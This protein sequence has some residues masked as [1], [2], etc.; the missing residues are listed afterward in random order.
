MVARME[1]TLRAQGARLDKLRVAVFGA[2]G[3]VGFAAGV[4]AALQGAEVTLAGYDGAA[5]VQR[6]AEDIARRFGAT[7]H[8]A[9]ASSEERKAAILAAA[10]AVF[11][12]GP[13]GRRLLS[14]EQL[15]AAPDLLVVADVNAV[16]PLG[17]EGVDLHDDGTPIGGG[18]TLG[19]GALAIGGTK[20][21][22]EFGLFRKMIESEQP[23]AYDFRDAFVLARELAGVSG[24]YA[25]IA[26]LSARA[27]AGSARR[28]GYLPLVA[29]LFGDLDTRAAAHSYARAGSLAHGFRRK[30]LLDALDALAAGRAPIGL[31]Y[32]SGFEDRPALLDAIGERHTA[33]GQRRGHRGA[34]QGSAGLCRAVPRRMTCRIPK[35]QRVSRLE[36]WGREAWLVKRIGGAGGT[37][38]THARAGRTPRRGRYAQRWVAGRP[39][40]ALF[41]GDG[42]AGVVL[43]FSAQWC[44]PLP[45][46][47]YRYGGA[48]RPAAVSRARA[49]AMTEAIARMIPALG[50]RGLNSADFLLRDDGFDLIEIN[51]RPGATLD[52]HPDA[53]GELFSQHVRACRG[54]LP[55]SAPPAEGAS[56]AAIVYAPRPLSVREG[57]AW[58][59]WT[60]DRQ[61][62]GPVA[63]HAP[64][65]TVR[66][67]APDA[68]GARV[69]AVERARSILALVS[70]P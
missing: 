69:V 64:L 16:P 54:K 67:E 70:G 50:L 32:G 25:L 46:R 21:R 19:I 10:Q 49:E 30:R 8:P 48:V 28:A 5:R 31:V 56:A 44:D 11:C 55:A 33:A 59:D 35:P 1:R 24:D 13:A 63:H 37:H 42:S 22:T 17:V 45:R 41:L 14:A 23:V 15:R 61:P 66:A 20:Y 18:K 43:G 47:P 53:G 2:T 34:H 68:D 27:L 3:V 6:A 40:S 38:I 60:A 62:C 12:A 52:V 58:P 7:V 39:V 51:P 36:A 57:F 65:C 26:A 9:D 29:D 4:I